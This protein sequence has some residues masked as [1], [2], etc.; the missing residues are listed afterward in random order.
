MLFIFSI[1][2]LLPF[3]FMVNILVAKPVCMF[4][5]M[6]YDKS[7]AVELLSQRM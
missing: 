2:S 7:P 3:S 6:P 5:K 1:S 4:T